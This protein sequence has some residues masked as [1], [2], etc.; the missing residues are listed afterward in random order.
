MTY[1][2]GGAMSEYPTWRNFFDVVIVAATKPAFFTEQRPL[3][4]RDGDDA[5][6]AQLPARARQA[7]TRAATSSDV[8][9][10]LGVTG[11]EVLYV[12]DHIYGDILRSKKDSAWRTAM[13]IQELE[14][15]IAAYESCKE[16]FETHRDARRSARAPRGRAPLLPGALQGAHAAHRALVGRATARADGSTRDLARSR[17]QAQQPAAP[18]SGATASTARAPSSRPIA[19][20]SS[21]P[22]SASAA[23]SAPDRRRADRDRAAHRSPLPPV[24]GLAPQGGRTSSRASASRSRS[25]RA[26]TRHASRTSSRTRRSRLPQPARRDGS[27]DRD[28]VT[29]SGHDAPARTDQERSRRLRRRGAPRLRAERRRARTSSCRFEK[30]NLTTDAAVRAITKALGIE[31]RD[32]GIAGMKDK[33]AVTTQWVSVPAP[34]KAADLE[35]RAK[36]LVHRRHQGPRREAPRQQAQDRSPQ[37][38][39][40]RHPRARRRARRGRG[41]P[42]GDGALRQGGRAQRVRRRSAS[43]RKATTPS[44]RARGSRA[45]SARPAIRAC[46]AS[47]SPR[48]SRRSSTR[49]S[50]RASRTAP[51]TSPCSATS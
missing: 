2:L 40:L 7:S 50:M 15:E 5:R 37:G 29:S 14:T 9:R 48:C 36:A 18:S 51:G 17:T 10:A 22:S 6:P 31:M 42:R 26:S 43:A 1:L 34:P 32:V 47:T 39:S 28:V 46:V 30:T 33:V 21:A 35:E 16:D 24:L 44:A 49:C 45:R 27:R 38:Q 20:A 41:H 23:S 12:G 4:E 19:C 11:D 25:T 8:E 13:I 3:L